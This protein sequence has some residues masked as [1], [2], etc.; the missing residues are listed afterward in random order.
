VYT[1]VAEAEEIRRL[2]PHAVLAAVEKAGHLPGSGQPER[3]NAGYGSAK[4]D[5]EWGNTPPP[6]T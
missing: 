4:S 2:V 5:A 1:P 6:S 3:F